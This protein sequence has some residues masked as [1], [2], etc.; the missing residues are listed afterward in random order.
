MKYFLQK[1]KKGKAVIRTGRNTVLG[2]CITKS[3]FGNQFSHTCRWLSILEA[4][5]FPKNCAAATQMLDKER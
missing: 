4:T 1:K 5:Q 2:S 3:S